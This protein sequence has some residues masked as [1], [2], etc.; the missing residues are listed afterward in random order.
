M[1]RS[2]RE[3]GIHGFDPSSPCR[4]FDINTFMAN[5]LSLFFLERGT[6]LTAGQ[7]DAPC[8]EFLGDDDRS[9]PIAPL[10]PPE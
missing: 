7:L 2:D 6:G 10:F 8:L 4:P 3:D 9:C 1:Q 5:Q